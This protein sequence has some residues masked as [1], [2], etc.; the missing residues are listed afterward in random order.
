MFYAIEYAYGSHV[1]NEGQRADKPYC[2]TARRLRDAWVNTGP[3]DTTAPGYRANASARHPLVRKADYLFD[4]DPLAW[5]V[6]AAARVDASPSL[7]PHRHDFVEYDWGDTNHARWVAT[8]KERE[9]T[10]WAKAVNG[11]L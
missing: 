6:L 11:K 10:E 1:V 7:M 2:F 4:G 8:A 5:A 9:L 3:F